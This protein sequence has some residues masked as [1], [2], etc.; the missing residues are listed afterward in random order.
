MCTIDGALS[1]VLVP[2][3]NR[4][5]V[6]SGQVSGSVFNDPGDGLDAKTSQ[7]HVSPVN[8]FIP[9]KAKWSHFDGAIKYP[10]NLEAGDC[11]F[12]PAF[13]FYHMQGY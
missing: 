8:F 12:I 2:H 6:Y 13:F 11:I 3:V 4:Q 5:E 7:Q 1:L 9:N 10:V